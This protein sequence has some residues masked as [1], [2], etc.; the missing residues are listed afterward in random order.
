MIDSGSQWHAMGL[1]VCEVAI[2][3]DVGDS[4]LYHSAIQRDLSS[5]FA[6]V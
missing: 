5:A 3:L 4:V 6:N 1:R 2:V